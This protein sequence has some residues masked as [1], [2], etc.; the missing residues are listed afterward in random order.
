TQLP[1]ASGWHP[2]LRLIDWIAG[3]SR[4]NLELIAAVACAYAALY[5]TEGIGLWLGERWAEYLTL[6]ATASLIPFELWELSRGP[7]AAK[8]AALAINVAI[9]AYLWRLVR[10]ERPRT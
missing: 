5:V 1:L 10:A 6:V 8:F 9:V 2:M 4:H 7:G 3:L